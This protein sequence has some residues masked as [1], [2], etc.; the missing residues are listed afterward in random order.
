MEYLWAVINKIGIGVL[1]KIIILTV[2]LFMS[3]L[4]ALGMDMHRNLYKPMPLHAVKQYD[5]LPGTSLR[6]LANELNSHGVLPRP[7]YLILYAR[8]KGIGARLQAGEYLFEPGLNVIGLLQKMQRGDVIMRSFTIIEGWTFRQL[9]NALREADTIEHTLPET[10]DDKQIM[11]VLGYPGEIPEGWFYPDTYL[12]PRGTTDIQFLRR[13][14]QTMA[15]F[16]EKAWADRSPDLP[17]KTP[18]QA[19]IMASIIEKESAVAA[20]R[21]LISAVF[22]NRLRKGMRLQTD[23][24][25]IYGLG[26]TFDGDIKFRDLRR[27]TPYNTYTRHGLPPTPIA[28]PSGAAIHAALHPADNPALYFVSMGDG[29]HKFSTN[30]ADHQDAV[31]RYQ[32]RRNN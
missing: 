18:Y 26:E 10:A 1:K 6:K 2:L 32:K 16:L 3:A 8:I 13:A 19:L 12:F 17:I 29:S 28:M 27:D 14:Y 21:P 31:N 20:E 25:V 22:T 4:I 9:I 5:L 23:P 15:D 7:F 30:L 24:T 11:Q